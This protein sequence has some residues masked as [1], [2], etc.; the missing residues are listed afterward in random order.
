MARDKY[1]V[2]IGLDYP[3]HGKGAPR[4]AEPGDIV[5]DL[6]AR[7]AADYLDVNAIEGPLTAARLKDLAA[8][9]PAATPVGADPD[10]SAAE[11]TEGEG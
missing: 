2:H 1:L 11:S 5:D 9:A 7:Q 6:T 3:P 4:R 10:P 8:A